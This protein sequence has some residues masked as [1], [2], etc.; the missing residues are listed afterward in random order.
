LQTTLSNPPGTAPSATG[1]VRR[2]GTMLADARQSLRPTG[3]TSGYPTNPGS[4]G[5][6]TQQLLDQV[7]AAR[8]A[9]DSLI[10]ILT[11]QAYQNYSYSVV[12][13]DLDTLAT[14]LANLDQSIRSGVAP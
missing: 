4:I 5:I 2:I 13:R 8:R 9:T 12:L 11:S 10:Q 1:I 7:T 14:R 3:S 6:G